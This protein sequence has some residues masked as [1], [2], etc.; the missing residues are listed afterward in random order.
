MRRTQLRQ[1][2]SGKRKALRLRHDDGV[3]GNETFFNENGKGKQKNNA[4]E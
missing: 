3:N 2:V 1:A 4:A